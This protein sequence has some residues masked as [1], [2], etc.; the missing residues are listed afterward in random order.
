MQ[1][2]ARLAIFLELTW[3]LPYYPYGE[4]R[5]KEP[6]ENR[7]SLGELVATDSNIDRQLDSSSVSWRSRRLHYRRT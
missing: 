1:S 3:N 4:N 7:D 6:E 5:I 2:D